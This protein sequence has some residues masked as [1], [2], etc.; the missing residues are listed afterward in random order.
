[1]ITFEFEFC[2]TLIQ[3]FFKLLIFFSS[4]VNELWLELDFDT[5]I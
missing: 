1:V 4:Y 5:L 2:N 3:T